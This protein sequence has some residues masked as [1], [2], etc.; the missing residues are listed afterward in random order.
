MR[1]ETNIP[2]RCLHKIYK[3]VYCTPAWI[4]IVHCVGMEIVS[5]LSLKRD[6]NTISDAF[7]IYIVPVY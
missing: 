3:T 5:N 4:V 2:A 7:T 6:R 1:A